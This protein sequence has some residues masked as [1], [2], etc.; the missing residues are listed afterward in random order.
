VLP[1]AAPAALRRALIVPNC[2][3]GLPAAGVEPIA[4]SGPWNSSARRSPS[5]VALRCCGRLEAAAADPRRLRLVARP[6]APPAPL[7][8][9]LSGR[10]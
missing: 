5:S 3:A 8:R 2:S 9:P 7:W 6:I 1:I 4:A 10:S